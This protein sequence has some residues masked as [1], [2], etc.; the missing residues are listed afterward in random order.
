M[1]GSVCIRC[2]AAAVQQRPG[3]KLVQVL[4]ALLHLLLRLTWVAAASCG[5]VVGSSGS[6]GIPSPGQGGG[7]TLARSQGSC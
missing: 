3:C 6:G 4:A 2:K 1:T 7:S 5:V